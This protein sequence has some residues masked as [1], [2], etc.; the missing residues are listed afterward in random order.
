MN[1]QGRIAPLGLA[2]MLLSAGIAGGQ[3]P[4]GNDLV[5]AAFPSNVQAEYSPQP[6]CDDVGMCGLFWDDNHNDPDTNR[7]DI[8]AAVISPQGQV[9]VQPTT[10]GTVDIATGPIAVGL[11]HGFA[12]LWDRQ[13]PDGHI[14]P[15]LQYYDESLTPQGNA[16]ALPFIKGAAGIHNPDSYEVFTTLVR[17]PSGFALYGTAPDSPSLAAGIFIFFIDRNGIPTHPRLQLNA[18]VS[19][20]S[21]IADFDGLAVQPN[22][23]LVAVYWRGGTGASDVYMRRF[24]ASGVLLG[25]EQRVNIHRKESQGQPVVAT[26]PDGSFLVVWQ[27]S[28]LPDSTSDILA[29][30]FSA[31]GKP[32]SDP[33]Q[34]NNVHQLDQRFP[35]ITADSQGDYFV[36]WQSYVPG[37]NWD[38]KGRL[39]RN[40]GTAVADEVRLNQVRQFEQESPQV[41][42]SPEGTVIAGWQSASVR[43]KGNEEFVPVVRVFSVPAQANRGTAGAGIP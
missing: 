4:L 13:F 7:I 3:T 22:G 5:I 27:E 33:F 32:L 10:L 39:F 8:L 11:E 1:G 21:V 6:V 43:Q 38:I 37:F 24:T 18:D 29:R 30:R 31:S 20:Q 25:P 9:Q 19:I 36:A 28:P 40:D 16:I 42:F 14:S 17:T 2:W 34:V 12:V 41:C 26:A 35:V 15:A 23:N